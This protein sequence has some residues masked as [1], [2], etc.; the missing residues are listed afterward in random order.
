MR[1]QQSLRINRINADLA[2]LHSMKEYWVKLKGFVGLHKPRKAI[3]MESVVDGVVVRGR[4]VLDV[5][6]RAFHNL[7][8]ASFGSDSFIP[9]FADSVRAEVEEW[10]DSKA[11]PCPELDEGFSR[12]EVNYAIKQLRR[13]KSAGVDGVVN[14]ILMYGGPVMEESIWKLCNIMFSCERIPRDWTRGIIFPLYKNGDERF[15]DNYRGITLLS[16]VAKLYSSLITNRV[17]KW[18][19]ENTKIS[20]AQAG[21]RPNR[22]T[23]DQIFTL[24]EILQARQ[25]DGLDTV[26]VFLDIKKAYDTT[27]REGVWKRLLEIGI[28]GKMWRVIRNLYNIVE[29]CVQLGA[30]FTEW[31]LI[32]LGLRQGDTLSPILYIVFIDGLINFLKNRKEGITL[33]SMKMNTLGFADDLSLLAGSKR[34]MQNLLDCAFIYSKRWRFLF[35]VS[36]SKVLVFSSQRTRMLAPDSEVLYLGL[37]QLDEVE[38]FTYL[39]VDFNFDLNWW[40]MKQRVLMKA[41]SRLALISK[42]I[43]NGLSP[44]ASLKLWNSLI[45]P[46]LEYSA[47]VWGGSRWPEAERLQLRFGR[48]VLGVRLTTSSDVVRGDLGLWTLAA[49]RDAAILRW[50]GKLVSMDQDRLCAIVYRYRRNNLRGRYS[51]CKKVKSLLE[52]LN[53]GHIWENEQIGDYKSWC[54]NV[55]ERIR[56]KERKD[57]LARVVQAPK[58][59]TY[60]LLKSQ[61]KFDDHLLEITEVEHR[62]QFTRLRSGTHDLAIDANRKYEEVAKRIC[63]LC[64]SGSVEDEQHFLLECFAYD[65]HR[66]QMFRDICDRTNDRYHLSSVMEQRDRL[67]QILVGEGVSDKSARTI[68]R[69]TVA[70]FIWQAM[71]FRSHCLQRTM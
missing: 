54:S 60:K 4:E 21:F 37:E 50:W 11:V 43:A 64:A 49:R 2:G 62:R 57:W 41:K 63:L 30:E 45:R 17:S 23:T 52:D 56:D 19:E 12:F 42:A 25:Q 59:R 8:S 36:K 10:L 15:P 67:L 53:L 33:G 47:E 46:V 51:W 24:A 9:D 61:L 20:D 22:A 34:A 44:L 16:V 48:Q 26:C 55:K 58:L 5:W 28:R 27:F 66:Q 13:G 14:E 69:R 18:C 70:K 65:S 29:S 32:D 68:I 35:S 7:G 1:Q 71:A 3:P 31:F 39:G 38:S 40:P 6:Q